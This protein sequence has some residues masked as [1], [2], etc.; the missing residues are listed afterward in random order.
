MNSTTPLYSPLSSD[1]DFRE[2]V[3]LFISELPERLESM[4]A[5]LAKQ[6]WSSLQK[7]AHQLKG[8]AGSYGFPLIS[9][10]AAELDATL[11]AGN[12]DAAAITKLVTTVAD[13]CR[14]ASDEPEPK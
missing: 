5:C 11:K 12:T 2:L 3:T 8:A 7:L 10:A 13:L 4:Q 14:R 9:P 6:D 1:P